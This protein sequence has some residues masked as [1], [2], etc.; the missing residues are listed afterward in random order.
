MSMR[1]VMVEK[2]KPVLP[3]KNNLNDIGHPLNVNSGIWVFVIH[4]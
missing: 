2:I 1:A 4:R 3:A